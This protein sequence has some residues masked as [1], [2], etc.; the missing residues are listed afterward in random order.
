MR[1]QDCRPINYFYKLPIKYKIYLSSDKTFKSTGAKYLV[2][3]QGYSL[4]DFLH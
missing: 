1:T 2:D 3:L 4:S